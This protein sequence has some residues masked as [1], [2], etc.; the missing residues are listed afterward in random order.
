VKLWSRFREGL[1]RTRDRIGEQVGGLLGLRTVDPA[2]R[3]ALEE[4]LLG[5]DV[6][7]SATERLI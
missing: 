7:P 2:T 1:Q 3:E 6:G 5:A 4:A